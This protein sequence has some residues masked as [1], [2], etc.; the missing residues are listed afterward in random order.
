MPYAPPRPFHTSIDDAVVII[1]IDTMSP[2]NAFGSAFALS[3]HRRSL[4]ETVSNLTCADEPFPLDIR[5]QFNMAVVRND[6]DTGI[7]C[8]FS[9]VTADS[10]APA[11]QTPQEGI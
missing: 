6:P 3:I 8:S 4:L 2:L 7:P 5:H 11:G 10:Q 1:Y 9:T